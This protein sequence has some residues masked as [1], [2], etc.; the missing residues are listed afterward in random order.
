[1]ICFLSLL[2][3]N[4]KQRP[5]PHHICSVFV[6]CPLRTG[7]S[8]KTNTKMTEKKQK[9]KKREMEGGEKE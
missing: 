9:E 7:E 6:C 4:K 2:K 1:M 3:G 8:K 5:P